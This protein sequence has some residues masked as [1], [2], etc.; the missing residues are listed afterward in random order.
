MA[1]Y[2]DEY[3]YQ[4]NNLYS[5]SFEYLDRADVKVSVNGVD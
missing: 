3:P 1:L 5:I 2:S 4:S